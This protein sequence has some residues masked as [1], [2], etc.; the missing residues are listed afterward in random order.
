MQIICCEPQLKLLTKRVECQFSFTLKARDYH[1]EKIKLK[2][3][4]VEML[5]C[6]KMCHGNVSLPKLLSVNYSSS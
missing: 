6:G 3:K 1:I 2:G 4:S 5:V